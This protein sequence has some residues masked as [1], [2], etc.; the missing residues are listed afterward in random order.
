MIQTR[1][2]LSIDELPKQYFNILS[3][4]NKIPGEFAPPLH[5]ATLQPVGPEDLAPLFPKELIKQEVSTDKFITIPE[6]VREI[7]A[8]YRPSP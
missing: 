2:D 4:F 8:R 6:P 7:Y 1:F 5:P 3:D